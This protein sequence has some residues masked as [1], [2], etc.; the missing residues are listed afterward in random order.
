MKHIC[1]EQLVPRQM[2][3]GIST[4]I[5]EIKICDWICF[6][7]AYSAW[8]CCFI[9]KFSLFSAEVVG[10]L[11]QKMYL[12]LHMTALGKQHAALKTFLILNSCQVD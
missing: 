10:V 1:I 12:L 11:D 6:E 8:V 9:M 4:N 5:G 2:V 3:S 7:L